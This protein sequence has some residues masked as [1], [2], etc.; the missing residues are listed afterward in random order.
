MNIDITKI[1]PGWTITGKRLIHGDS[2]YFL[3]K[4]E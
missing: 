4:K 1:W 2:I 3:D